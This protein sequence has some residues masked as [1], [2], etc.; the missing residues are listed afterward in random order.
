MA[1]EYFATTLENCAEKV[2]LKPFFLLDTAAV[3]EDRA[4]SCG[5]VTWQKPSS[6]LLLAGSSFPFLFSLHVDDPVSN[7][8]I[9]K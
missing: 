5:V 2:L 4:V 7:W 6:L 9:G 3:L 8:I 1:R